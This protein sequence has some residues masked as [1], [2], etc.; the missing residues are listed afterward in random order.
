M[1]DSVSLVREAEGGKHTNTNTQIRQYKRKNKQ[2]QFRVLC[3][4]VSVGWEAEGG[5]HRPQECD[6]LAKKNF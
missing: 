3:D 4:S 2:I 1:C 5:R 6:A